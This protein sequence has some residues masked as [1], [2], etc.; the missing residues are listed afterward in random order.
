MSELAASRGKISKS[1][2]K[3]IWIPLGP[4]PPADGKRAVMG[5]RE[6]RGALHRLGIKA[7]HFGSKFVVDK[8]LRNS[9]L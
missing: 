9:A 5:L 6:A 7:K 2:S 4:V 3:K 1:G 8:K